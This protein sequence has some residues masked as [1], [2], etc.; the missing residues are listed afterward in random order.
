MAFWIMKTVYNLNSF[1]KVA[2]ILFE[3]FVLLL[4]V[5]YVDW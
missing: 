2:N 3:K 4:R 1:K 5:Q